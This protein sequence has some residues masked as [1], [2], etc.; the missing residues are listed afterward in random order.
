[1]VDQRKS[2]LDA[3]LDEFSASGLNGASVESIADRAQVSP[4]VVRALFVDKERLVVTVLRE[5]TEPLVSAIALTVKRSKTTAER[6]RQTIE[7][8]DD[9]LLEDHRYIRFLQWC[10]LE[11]PDSIHKLYEQ[12]FYPSE[13]FEQIEEDINAGRIRARD[14]FTVVLILDSLMFF[15]YFIR[16]ALEQLR[17][18]LTA[19][20]LMEKR[21][22]AI[23]D[24]LENGLIRK[25][26]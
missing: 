16:P 12:S 8:M 23:M 13:Y 7:L 25:D 15:S 18:D 1:M 26:E 6:T 5:S 3:A 17:P 24:L 21:R 20:T 4:A 14:P 19:E 10:F 11:R 9:W 22:D 2:I